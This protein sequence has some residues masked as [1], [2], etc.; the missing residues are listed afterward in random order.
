M[1]MKTTDKYSPISDFY[2]GRSIFMTGGT[3]FLGIVLIEKLLYGCPDIGN[4]YILIREKKGVSPEERVKSL[5]NSPIFERLK[6]DKPENLKKII[7]VIGDLTELNLGISTQDLQILYDEVSVVFHL[8]ATIKFNEPLSVAVKINVGGTEEVI[9]ICQN[10]KNIEVFVYMSTIFS[11]TDHERKTIVEKLYP[12]PKHMDEVYRMIEE[13]DPKETFSPEV[14]CGRPNTYTFTKALAE[15]VVAEKRGDLPTVMIRPSVVTPIKDEPAKGWIANWMGPTPILTLLAKGWIRGLYGENDYTFEIIPVDYVVNMTI[16]AA[17]RHNRSKEL[18]IYHSCSTADNP[19]TV[20]DAK[21]NYLKE[22]TKHNFNEL[23]FPGLIFTTSHWLL[24]I[25]AFI[26]Q[27]IPA[28]LGDLVLYLSGK[29]IRFIKMLKKLEICVSTLRYFSSRCWAMKAS[30]AQA[31]I[32]TLSEQDKKKFP[33]D[34]RDIN[35]EEYMA[36]YFNGVNK[37]LINRS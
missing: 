34:P 32:S 17:A 1:I 23:P 7:P 35:W 2:A 37:Y 13:N 30:R 12:S 21:I 11:N 31:L 24:F 26:F 25:L 16:I 4:I 33:C 36:T 6:A 27:T 15:N 8:A 18:S 14:L 5:I 22:S 3:G 28:Y 10:M 19:L 9:K 29:P 20:L